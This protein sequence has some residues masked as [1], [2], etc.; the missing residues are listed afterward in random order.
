M[1]PICI[2]SET[3]NFSTSKIAL[4]PKF[5]IKSIINSL[6]ETN[7]FWFENMRTKWIKRNQV[8]RIMIVVNKNKN[9]LKRM[10]IISKPSSSIFQLRSSKPITFQLL[11]RLMIWSTS[12]Q[13]SRLREATE[14]GLRP[15][16]QKSCTL[17]CKLYKN[18]C[19]QIFKNFATSDMATCSYFEKVSSLSVTSQ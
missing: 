12:C 5:K 11:T 19:T 15:A 8:N 2:L 9:K 6:T 13:T 18:K 10:M 7:M 1:V 4:Q 14:L 16:N 17:H 3:N